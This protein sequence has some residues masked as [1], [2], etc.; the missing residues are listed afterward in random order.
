MNVEESLK[1]VIELKILEGNEEKLCGKSVKKLK[2][3]VTEMFPHDNSCLELELF[4]YIL[5][6]V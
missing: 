5:M 2:R 1:I 4:K 6:K 3:I